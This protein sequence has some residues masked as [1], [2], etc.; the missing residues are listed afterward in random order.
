VV[1]E[2]VAKLHEQLI[3]AKAKHEAGR[4][5]EALTLVEEV[6][7]EGI[8]LDYE[9]LLA[10][11][12]LQQGTLQWE[13]AR[14]DEAEATLRRALDAALARG[15]RAEAARAS[16]ELVWVVGYQQARYDEA[17][18]WIELSEALVRAVPT[19]EARAN[20]LHVLG[21]VA[22][23]DGEYD[24]ARDHH[25]RALAIQ[26]QTLSSDHPDIAY[27][28]NEL[29]M[30]AL[31]TGDVDTAREHFERALSILEIAL[32]PDH[33]NVA[34]SITNLGIAADSEQEYA[35]A[36]KHFER[37]LAI[38]TSA[39]G[40]DHPSV[41]GCLT[42]LALVAEAEGD[43]ELAHETFERARA[44][45]ERALGPEHPEMAKVHQNLGVVAYKAGKYEEAHDYH[46]RAV[47]LYAKTALSADHPEVKEA[48][49]YLAMS[50]LELER[51]AEA[52]EH[53]ERALP[54]THLDGPTDLARTRFALARAL[55]DAPEEQGRDR[56]RARELAELART[57]YAEAKA[58]TLQEVET[59][60]LEHP[61]N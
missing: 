44:S 14:H 27:T 9:P 40:P 61:A 46:S 8:T 37:A 11:A 10:R 16:T 3:A 23:G 52:I 59:W 13:K 41:T 26:E 12:W 33:P 49:V 4:Y 50:L 57:T 35:D 17:R 43:Y 47:A 38:R 22:W 55:W 53:L 7:A 29:G 21:A 20:R 25:A 36:R 19:T 34:N 51:P 15:M 1:A 2:R 45:F 39:L 42:N 58:E 60:L 48:L 6:V 30:A 54:M 18:R 32:G 31:V 24:E 5:D 28:L 56:V